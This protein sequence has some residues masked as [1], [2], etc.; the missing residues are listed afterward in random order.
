MLTEFEPVCAAVLSS[1]CGS[2]AGTAD[3]ASVVDGG[4]SFATLGS[5]P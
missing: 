2:V 4:C 1:A 3:P 5:R